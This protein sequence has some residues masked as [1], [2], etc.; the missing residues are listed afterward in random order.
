MDIDFTKYKYIKVILI[1]G[2]GRSKP[3]YEVRCQVSSK[4]WYL[5]HCQLQSTGEYAFYGS[6]WSLPK[7]NHLREIA[8]LLDELN[9]T[10]K[11]EK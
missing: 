4:S 10:I 1:K 6:V 8:N 11:G 5:G 3:K 7:S 2:K 9:K